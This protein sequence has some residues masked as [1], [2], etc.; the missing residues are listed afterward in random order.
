MNRIKRVLSLAL[1]I[2]MTL[3]L[4]IIPANAASF[5]DI[6][7]HWAE[8]LIEQA[9][10]HGYVPAG[11]DFQPNKA[12]TRNEFA[13]MVNG[14]FGL[15]AT[16]NISFTDVPTSDPYYK[17][18]QKAVSAGYIA[19]YEDNTFRGTNL[20]TRQEAAVII[21]RLVAHPG[22]LS[23]MNTLT[24]A[25]SIAAWAQPAA[26]A[27]FTKGYMVGDNLKKFNP[28]GNLTRA[29]TVKILE[30]ILAKEKII[31]GNITIYGKNDT[32]TN[33]VYTGNLVINESIGRSSVQLTNCKVLGTLLVNGGGESGI[34][35]S[36]TGVANLTVDSQ[37]TDVGV[38]AVGDST[39][40]NTYL[41]TSS[42]LVENSISG[43]G[44][45]FKNVVIGGT[46]A[47]VSLTGTTY[48]NVSINTP[49]TLTLTSGK[50]TNLNVAAA[51]I[52]TSV[53][54]ESGTNVANANVNTAVTFTG[55]GTV[56]KTNGTSTGTGTGTTTGTALAYTTTPATGTT[57]VAT[58][59]N[60]A[61]TF[62]DVIV[63][64]NGQ[65]LTTSWVRNNV[66]LRENNANG[67]T[68]D[69]SA[70]ISQSG[71][72]LTIDP[73][74]SLKTGTEYL[75]T[76]N[77]NAF[78]GSTNGRVNTAIAV[79][80]STDGKS[81]GSSSSKPSI[82]IDD[83]EPEFYPGDE[84]DNIPVGADLTLT[85]EEKIYDEDGKNLT[86]TYLKDVI[87]LRKGSES[88]T[89]VKFTASINSAKK[90][91]TINPSSNLTKNTTYYL[92]VEEGALTNSDDDSNDELVYSFKTANSTGYVPL[93]TPASGS[94]I[95][96][97]SDFVFYFEDGIY[98]DEGD[99]LTSSYLENY[100]F[101]IREGSKTGTKI[102]FE[103]DID[104]DDE[105][106]TL[107]TEELLDDDETYYVIMDGDDLAD[108]D[109]NTLPDL[110][111]TFYTSDDIV[112]KND[113]PT[114]SG[115]LAPIETSPEHKDTG[116]KASDNIKMLFSETL[117]NATGK[118]VSDDDLEDAIEIRRN[119]QTGSK[120]GFNA[121]YDTTYGLNVVELDPKSS[122][123]VGS[124]YYVIVKEG[125]LFDK[126][127]NANDEFV[128]YFTVGTSGSTSELE[129]DVEADDDSAKLTIEYDYSDYDA[130]KAYM[131]VYYRKDG[132]SW[133]TSSCNNAL[134]ST[135]LY[136]T[137][138]VN[139]SNLDED[140][141]YE[142]EVEVKL[143]D[144]AILVDT[145]SYED[146]FETDDDY[147]DED[148]INISTI[149]VSG[150]TGSSDYIYYDEFE[151]D[152]GVFVGELWD[153]IEPSS[154]LSYDYGRL[155]VKVNTDDSNAT[156]YVESDGDY[157]YGDDN[158]TL[159]IEISEDEYDDDCVVLYI[160]V[161]DSDGYEIE[162]E[163]TVWLEY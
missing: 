90:V 86:S 59:S 49:S 106:I 33:T 29:E 140:E 152:D 159:Y 7:G 60:I 73:V 19:G 41:K 130:T 88:G 39:V 70:S 128:F 133:K 134:L 30:A 71:K 161:E 120:I 117:Y 148:D 21:A 20:I 118:K 143:Y 27:V 94:T 11:G 43:M 131:T 145:D 115:D 78:K 105:T 137:K 129:V 138:T 113:K 132:G 103:A 85:F 126:N 72:I 26:K 64:T 155:K 42:Q 99:Y 55:K 9:V 32:I 65:I 121:S 109:G 16:A 119:S 50:I 57:K 102:D 58:T 97:D 36:N 116:V 56:T 46:S 15:T 45:G 17:D 53:K 84:T 93:A 107:V 10:A 114:I 5:N 69:Y 125:E 8:K 139:L 95:E 75:L 28:Y 144:G 142:F 35:L 157:T 37:W 141:T 151:Y 91:I 68:V 149:T 54:L 22:N 96:T 111:F 67:T 89:E 123:S 79:A 83:M 108:I 110:T 77:P 63:P 2:G 66:V 162:Y 61:I 81:S 101:E 153:S 135:N 98:D 3:S 76:V 136:G 160:T 158:E 112:N 44:A 82:S 154:S 52:G 147:Y 146:T 14:A 80:F 62:E 100:V 163:L 18:V 51:A 150:A 24:D 1:A 13:R 48:D 104:D 12:I 127:D 6:S 38:A 4:L 34:R 87:E 156:V 124:K 122:L 31:S 92:I 25:S 40:Y 74:A 23:N 47:K